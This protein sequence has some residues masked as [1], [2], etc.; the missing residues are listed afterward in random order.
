MK[1]KTKIIIAVLSIALVAGGAWLANYLIRYQFYDDYKDYTKEY[2]FE[3]EENAAAFTPIAESKSDV[4]GMALVCENENLKLYT[5]TETAEVAVYDKRNGKTVYSNPQDADEDAIANQV[6]KNYLKS[7][8]V[9]DYFNTGRT[10]STYDSYSVGVANGQVE[11]QAMENGIRYIYEIGDT[12]S[13]TGIVPVYIRQERLQEFMSRIDERD[14][15]K[16]MNNYVESSIG[17]GWMELME[18]S[19]K[20]AGTLRR[21]TGYFEEAGYTQEDYEQ[22]MME[23]GVEGAMNISFK[24]AL[25]Y[26]L[27]D[28]SLVVTLPTT[29]IE[30]RGG[31]YIYRVQLLRYMGAAGTEEDGYMLVP[32]GSGSLI[33]F[34]NGKT[35]TEEYSQ[36]IYGIDALSMAYTVIDIGEDIRMPLYGISRPDSGVLVT[37]E[38]GQSLAS[39]TASVAGRVNEYNFVYPTFSLRGTD[40]LSMFGATGNEAELPILE[41]DYYKTDCTVRYTFLTEENASYA[42]MANYQ[43]NRLIEEGKL[44]LNGAQGDIPFYYDIIGGVK[45]TNYFLGAQYLSVE[46]MTTFEEA[47]K[48]SDDLAA[49]G[50]SNQVMNLQ[51]WSNGGYYH[52]VPDKI[53]VI[54][55]LGGKKGLQELNDTLTVNGGRLYVDNAM[56]KVTYISKRYKDNYE[57]SRYY[58][59][60]YIASF[61]QLS[62]ISLRQTASLGYEETLYDLMSPKFLVRYVEEFV[63][64]ME[65]IDNVGISLRDMGDNLYSDKKR[66]EVIDRNQAMYILEA[67]LEKIDGLGRYMMV[68][69]GNDYTFAYA[70]DIL[71]APIS[72]NDYFICDEEVPFY[73]ILVHG[74]INYTGKPINLSDV[75]DRTDIV[76]QL[77]ENGASP[78]FTF[79][80]EESNQMKYSGLNRYYA[81]TY[82][83]WKDDA[84]AIYNEVNEALKYVNGATITDHQICDG[85]V[86]KITY[87]NG[88]TCYINTSDTDVTVDGKVIVSRSYEMEGI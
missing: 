49:Q 24:L 79:T 63:D 8:L 56:Q 58:G 78:H 46:P 35:S 12:S 61:G 37:I 40:R 20:G 54:G 75:Y 16:A 48:I 62:P 33:Y 74:C 87:S 83:N 6:H 15:R 23:S 42:A 50:I 85:G 41:T 22:D 11:A 36:F 26:R 84:V 29:S 53:K 25:E 51:G 71:N 39:I 69:G 59:G 45:L 80:W 57:S 1:R 66:T 9:V 55:K 5:N 21:L 81:T 13:P 34:N 32:N 73:E 7:Q 68:S 43:R 77:I 38:D 4:P 3:Y 30:E 88:V 14:A 60:G 76:L 31:G 17:D 44:A 64:E 2:A 86:R 65:K 19:Q 52:D 27:E 82:A 72:H 18:S 67:Q 70:D 28:E 47:G 10:S